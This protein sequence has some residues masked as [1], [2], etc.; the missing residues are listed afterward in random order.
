MDL[1]FQE[2]SILGSLIITV[3]LFGYYFLKV[4]KILTSGSSADA[5]MLPSILIGVVVAVVV[6]EIVYHIL[7]TLR[8]E[9]M[10]D[11]RDKLIEAKATRYSYIVLVAGC[12]TTVG[13]SL[14]S[15]LAQE[16]AQE[17]LI[18][19]P[20]MFANLI[21]FSFIIAEIVGFSMQLYFYRRGV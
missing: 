18:Q 21:I 10:D 5:L 8:S 6:V 11:E 3:G 4:F 17:R 12:L 16:P 13:H 1:S 19:A 7:I 20:I 2:K 15:V 14:F 9:P